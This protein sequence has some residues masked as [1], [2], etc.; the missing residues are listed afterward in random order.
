MIYVWTLNSGKLL[1]ASL[2]YGVF[3][4]TAD[5]FTKSIFKIYITYF[6]NNKTC[7]VILDIYTDEAVFQRLELKFAS[8]MRELSSDNRA[9]KKQLRYT[10]GKFHII[11]S[12]S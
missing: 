12:L 1:Y 4:T 8:K 7:Y 11:L 2:I 6:E 5:T 10:Q 9:L 3:T